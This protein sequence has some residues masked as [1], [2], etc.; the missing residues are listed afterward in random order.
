MKTDVDQLQVHWEA[1]KE[2]AISS[3]DDHV[4]KIVYTCFEEYRVHGNPSYF[5]TASKYV[6]MFA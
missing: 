6:E 4:P 5:S 3:N 1:L 2:K